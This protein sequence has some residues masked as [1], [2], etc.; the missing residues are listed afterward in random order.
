MEIPSRAER[1]AAPGDH[2]GSKRNV[3]RHHQVTG[4]YLLNVVIVGH[5]EPGGDLN[6]ADVPGPRH[7]EWLVGD[8]DQVYADPVSGAIQDLV[9]HPRAGI[10]IHPYLS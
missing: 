8:Q 10:G 6:R 3:G 4:L 2:L 7:L 9:D 5:I 1:Q